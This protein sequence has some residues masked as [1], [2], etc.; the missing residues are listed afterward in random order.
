MG[1]G[2]AG[3]GAAS[4]RLRRGK[5]QVGEQR[6]AAGTRCGCTW[7]VLGTRWVSVDDASKECRGISAGKS[8]RSLM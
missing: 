3:R 2:A 4:C 6:A 1:H 7:G 8:S 5:L